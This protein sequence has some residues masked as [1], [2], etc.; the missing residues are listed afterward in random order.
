MPLAMLRARWAGAEL[1]LLIFILGFHLVP[2]SLVII[3][4]LVEIFGTVVFDSDYQ[5]N[6]TSKNCVLSW[7]VFSV[8]HD[9][10]SHFASF[11]KIALTLTAPNQENNQDRRSE[12]APN[13]E[14]RRCNLQN[15]K[16]D[17]RD[18]IQYL[19]YCTVHTCR[20][21]GKRLQKNDLHRNMHRSIVWMVRSP[22]V[23]VNRTEQ[24]RTLDA[25]SHWNL[26]S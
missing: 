23:S 5:H 10:G 21:Q 11:L 8:W 16:W 25:L 24:N 6:V 19:I 4:T 15:K 2:H 14:A 17:S 18:W 26:I 1:S 13:T 20:V 7:I 12:A 9:L 3:L 22:C